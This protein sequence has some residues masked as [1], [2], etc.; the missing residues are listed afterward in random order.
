MWPG[1]TASTRNMAY[2]STAADGTDRPRYDRQT[3]KFG[4]AVLNMDYRG[5]TARFSADLGYQATNLSPPLRFLTFNNSP[6]FAPRFRF[7]RCRGQGPTTC[8]PGRRGSRKT[9]SR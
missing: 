3:E 5:E 2:A 4:N 8:R 6:P 7:R 9:L 1:A